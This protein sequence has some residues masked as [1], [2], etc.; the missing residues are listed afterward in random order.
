MWKGKCQATNQ[1]N[2]NRLFW[3]VRDYFC[4]NN[5]TTEMVICVLYSVESKLRQKGERDKHYSGL[6]HCIFMRYGNLLADHD[7]LW[8]SQST[9]P[10]NEKLKLNHGTIGCLYFARAPTATS[11]QPFAS[12]SL[13]IIQQGGSSLVGWK[14]INCR[15]DT[16]VILSAVDI[17][18][19]LKKVLE[20]HDTLLR[21]HRNQ[22][23]HCKKNLR[24]AASQFHLIADHF[25]KPTHCNTGQQRQR[26]KMKVYQHGD[27]NCCCNTIT[28]Y[29]LIWWYGFWH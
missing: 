28:T 14:V 11:C 2:Q 29:V 24:S 15:N 13:Q 16:H 20:K 18:P 6:Q 12:T 21:N 19:E 10:S 23:R 17:V 27:E 8:N 25:L 9:Q 4:F 1:N 3:V 7:F 26:G 5:H 22:F